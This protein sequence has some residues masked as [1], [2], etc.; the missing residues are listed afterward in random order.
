MMCPQKPCL[1]IDIC[2][3]GQGTKTTAGLQ[4][5]QWKETLKSAERV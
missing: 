4:S 3:T 5:Q 1:Y 2:L